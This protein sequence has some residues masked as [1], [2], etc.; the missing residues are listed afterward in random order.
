M[1]LAACHSRDWRL[2]MKT[3][4]LSLDFLDNPAYETFA[5]LSG[6]TFEQLSTQTGVPVELFDD[7]PRS[8]RL[9]DATPVRSRPR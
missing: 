4:R 2:K 1:K 7:D 9:R 8:D 5:A 6:L 3:G